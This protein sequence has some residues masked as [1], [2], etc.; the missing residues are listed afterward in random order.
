MHNKTAIH[1]SVIDVV[2]DSKLQYF[3]NSLESLVAQTIT[4]FELVL[5][6]GYPGTETLAYLEGQEFPFD[7]VKPVPDSICP[8][9][10][11]RSINQNQKVPIGSRG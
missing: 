1:P 6:I 11:D 2:V 10:S 3:K 5:V 8:L 4:D 9:I 7:F